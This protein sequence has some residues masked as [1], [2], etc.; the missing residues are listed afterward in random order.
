MKLTPTDVIAAFEREAIAIESALYAHPNLG[1]ILRKQTAGIP[2]EELTRAYAR[3][4][5]M[6]A[7]YVAHTV[8]M[9][10]ATAKALALGDDED[11]KISEH[12]A[13]YADE[14][15]DH[16]EQYGHEA[17]AFNDIRALGHAHLI[18][19]EPP[20]ATALYGNYFVHDAHLHPHAIRGA[21][22]VL[23]HLSILNAEKFETGLRLAGIP[24]I[25]NAMQFIKSHGT[26]DIDH[27]RASD[28]QLAHL[29][30]PKKLEQILHG[31]YFTGG[32]YRAMLDWI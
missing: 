9:L 2:T 20:N 31:A 12:F 16:Q 17:W 7:S 10:K 13:H 6:T 25:D 4:L 8:P 21:K 3:W 22:G 29:T 24:N 5:K 23:E 30:D 14:E 27:V 15:F 1:P 11:K 32:S 28:E 18:T 19:E 26:L